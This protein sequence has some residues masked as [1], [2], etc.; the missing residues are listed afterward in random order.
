MQ[1]AMLAENFFKVVEMEMRYGQSVDNPQ[2]KL[3]LADE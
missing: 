1:H 2:K 3:Q